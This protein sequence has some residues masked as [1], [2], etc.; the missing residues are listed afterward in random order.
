MS[1]LIVL[2]TLAL[3][4]AGVYLYFKKKNETAS[5]TDTSPKV[6]ENDKTTTESIAV[7]EEPNSSPA[8]N[9]ANESVE[10]KT[11]EI[12]TTETESIETSSSE[13]PIAEIQPEIIANKAESTIID[14]A[15]TYTTSTLTQ[16]EVL[17]SVIVETHSHSST[18]PNLPEDSSLRRHYLT[19]L[20]AK[21]V[22]DLAP[23]PTDSTLKRHYD[24]MLQY[25]L[26]QAISN[27]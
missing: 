23:S 25:K 5:S 20:K 12:K 1:V 10:T 14:Q 3:L 4:G 22:A 19:E 13:A 26:D 6:P 8:L 21:V 9:T 15:A 18:K 11:P 16:P 17:T 24:S 2:F 27:D 7:S